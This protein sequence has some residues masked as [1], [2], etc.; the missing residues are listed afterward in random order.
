MKK[1]IAAA[2]YLCVVL[3]NSRETHRW[4]QIWFDWDE[5]KKT[6]NHINILALI[7]DLYDSLDVLGTKVLNI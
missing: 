5:S 7:L 3:K 1:T 4:S 2:L 6:Y